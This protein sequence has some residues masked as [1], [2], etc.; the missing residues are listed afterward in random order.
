RL[1]Q[2]LGNRSKTTCFMS[3]SSFSGKAGIS[4]QPMTVH[5]FK[6]SS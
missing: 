6:T 5:F 3:F 4:L 2:Y 1:D